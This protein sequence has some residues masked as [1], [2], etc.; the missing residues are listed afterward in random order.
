MLAFRLMLCVN[1]SH[2]KEPI[3]VVRLLLVAETVPVVAEVIG[4]NDPQAPPAVPP[5]KNPVQE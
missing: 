5:T 2:G 4:S 1:T 3:V